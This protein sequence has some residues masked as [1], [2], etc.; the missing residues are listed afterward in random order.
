M[1]GDRFD[2][3]VRSLARDTSRRNVI[4]GLVGGAVGGMLTIARLNRSD[5]APAKKVNVCHRTGSATN[6]FVYISVSAN[7]VPAHQAHGDAINPD[8]Q[9]D[10]NNCGGCGIVCDDGDP[11]TTNACVAGSCVYT[12]IDCSSLDD[13]CLKGVCVGGA[14]E[15]QA[16]NEGGSCDDGNACTTN[17]TCVAGT[18]T[19]GPALD[20]DDGNVCTSDSCDPS[21]GCVYEQ[22]DGC[23]N[24]NSECDDGDSCT[25]DTCV[26]HACVSE[27]IACNVGQACLNGECVGC[28]GGTCSN[29]PACPDD[30]GCICFITTEG[31]G[32]CHRSELCAGLQSCT[33]SA[34]CP[35][36]HPACS[37]ATCCGDVH[38]CIRP[39]AG[40]E[41]IAAPSS[42]D[43]GED[44]EPG[45]M[46][47]GN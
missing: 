35:A 39:C 24:L 42:L 5:A 29:L 23:C 31:T 13:Q 9:N 21:V 38:V 41:G 11:C 19:G 22:I 1:D 18:C 40:T 10:I 7:A 37:T 33:S 45:L 26:N 6:P 36:D 17:D 34:D 12:A 20:C 28:E 25:T 8:F 15:A 3:L 30:A 43:A 47:G 27:P 2:K 16:A 46:T 32:F 44:G 4:K 14:C